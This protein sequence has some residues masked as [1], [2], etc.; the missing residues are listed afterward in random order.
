MPTDSTFIRVAP[1]I[2][3]QSHGVMVVRGAQCPIAVFAHEGSVFAVDNRCP[4]L[5]FPLHRGS[6][7]DGILTCHWHHARFDLCS[8]CTFD[9]F[10]DDV[11][12]FRVEVRDGVVYVAASPN[13]EPRRDYFYHRLRE[14]MAQNIS[15]IQAKSLL[16]LLQTG[17]DYQEIIR[18]V[19]LFGVRNRRGF[20]PGLVLLTTVAN[21][22]PHLEE[23]TRYFAL[24]QATRQVAADCAGQAPRRPLLPLESDEIS[25][26][27][28]KRWLRYWT[29]VRHE[30][31]A[32][33]TLLTA[34]HNEASRSD[35]ADM[36]FAA[37]TDRI[38]ADGGHLLDF[39]NKAFELLDFIGWENASEVLPTL[40]PQLVN[41]RGAEEMKAWRHPLD[42]VAVLR[43][44]EAEFPQL[45]LTR[46]TSGEKWDGELELSH[47]MLGDDALKI[48]A[49][50]RQAI[51]AGAQ[52]EQLARALTHAAA[53]RL[54]RF[55]TANEVG[56]WFNP[57]HTFTYC[58]AVYQ[59]LRRLPSLEIQRAI[60][61]G[62]MSVY[63][64]RF[65]NVPPAKLPGEHEALQAT[66]QSA[67]ELRQAFLDSLDQRHEVEAAARLVAQ[68]CQHDG[69]ISSFFDTFMRATTREDLDFHAYQMLEASLRQFEA[70]KIEGEHILLGQARYLAAHCPTQ[71]A[72]SHTA[73]IA[74]RLQ[75]GDNLYEDEN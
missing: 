22:L 51:L 2:E 70:W 54:A 33:R 25:H 28:L 67:D 62:A 44:W 66:Q 43:D 15:L 56:D 27:T 74:L 68:Y 64:D 21:T 72:R 60:F 71:R 65:L 29:E 3:L 49:A 11:P 45:Y 40:V 46:S 16:G 63:L 20:G 30:E 31:A 55:S 50:A 59:A 53:M 38:Y 42:L 57:M 61:H 8:G 5:G 13:R 34:I 48:I 37:A 6:V 10:A 19:A 12:A 18:E 1:L 24:Y 32:E 47:A 52:P 73:R 7:Q 17:A 58:N 35:L 9:P 75:R 26:S 36:I 4:H 41:A 69:S 23:E 14:G 39:C